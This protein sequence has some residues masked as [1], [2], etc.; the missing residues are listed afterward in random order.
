[1]AALARA[2]RHGTGRVAKRTDAARLRDRPG[3]V[4]ATGRYPRLVR[5]ARRRAVRAARDLAR[6][7]AAR[8]VQTADGPLA[9]AR[10][11][12][13]R[14]ARQTRA[15]IQPPRLQRREADVRAVSRPALTVLTTPV[16]PAAR[17]AYVRLRG[18]GRRILKPGTPGL[19]GSR[20]PGHYAVTRSVVEGLRL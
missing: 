16:I 9:P 1:A 3:A 18:I 13:S 7:G 15:H 14:S 5:H 4:V 10:S 6:A 8:R 19:S 17:R 2:D 12:V 11:F 20:Y